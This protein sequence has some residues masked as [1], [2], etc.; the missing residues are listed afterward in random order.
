MHGQPA[1]CFAYAPADLFP[2][3]AG[4]PTNLTISS[5]SI[6]NKAVECSQKP[7][8][9]FRRVCGLMSLTQNSAGLAQVTPVEN[10]ISRGSSCRFYIYMQCTV[11][12][13]TQV[14]LAI[15]SSDGLQHRIKF[16]KFP[17]AMNSVGV[18]CRNI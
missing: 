2:D 10:L 3:H 9:L 4:S 11:G 6:P 8:P 18:T 17:I 15:R 13:I 5:V 7:L 16:L 12:L 1:L 14:S